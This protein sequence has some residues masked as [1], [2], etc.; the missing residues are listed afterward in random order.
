MQ[1][2]EAILTAS[3]EQS[4]LSLFC[5]LCLSLLSSLLSGTCG[6]QNIFPVFLLAYI[7]ICIHTYIVYVH[8]YIYTIHI[9]THIHTIYTHSQ[10]GLSLFYIFRS[11]LY[12]F[13]FILLFSSQLCG[14]SPKSSGI[15]Y[16][17]SSFLM[18]T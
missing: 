5:F 9:Y 16:S 11:F 17:K 15:I 13:F 2:G 6:Y 10:S 4:C 12:T 8:I 3:F 14:R 1:K 7:I 18:V